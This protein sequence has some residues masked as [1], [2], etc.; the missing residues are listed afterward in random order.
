MSKSLSMDFCERLIS[1]VEGVCHGARR[2]SNGLI[3][4]GVLA[5]LDRVLGMVIIDPITLKPMPMRS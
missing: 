3:R 2:R 1:A 5:A 4:S